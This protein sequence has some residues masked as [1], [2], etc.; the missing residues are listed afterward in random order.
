[1]DG[2]ACRPS[3]PL[4]LRLLRRLR[5]CP[6]R[7]LHRVAATC[8]AAAV[9]LLRGA[10]GLA[11]LALPRVRRSPPRLRERP[12]GGSLPWARPPAPAGVEGARAPPRSSPRGRG[13]EDEAPGARGRR[14]HARP[15]GRGP[16]ARTRA[17]PCGRACRSARIGVGGRDGGVA[18]ALGSEPPP[19]RAPPGRAWA[20]RT[21]RVRRRRAT[22]RAGAARRRRLHDGGDCSGRRDRPAEGGGILRAGDHFREGGALD[23]AQRD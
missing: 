21:R 14:D 20:K 22:A 11:G 12:G 15:A 17:A 10:D 23:W 2:V 1:M 18:H 6:V 13:R 5:R 8:L 9:R 4:A 16:A 7:R 19:D 3:L